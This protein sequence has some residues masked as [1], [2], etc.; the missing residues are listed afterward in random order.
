MAPKLG[1]PLLAVKVPGGV[2]LLVHNP[3]FVPDE[4]PHSEKHHATEDTDFV[5]FDVCAPDVS[6]TQQRRRGLGARDVF[7][8]GPS[9]LVL[10]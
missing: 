10:S 1:T 8:N 9:T 5:A 2:P 6:V 4:L 3:A 7:G